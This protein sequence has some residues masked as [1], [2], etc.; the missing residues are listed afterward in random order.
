[1]ASVTFKGAKVQTSG[2]LP[3]VG[4]KAPDFIL[5]DSDLKDRTLN[6]FRGRRKLISIVPSLDTAVCAL[7][8]KKFNDAAKEHPGITILF[9]S[10]DLPFAQKRFCVGD[11][12][13]NIVT[14]SMMR[15]K[16]FAQKYGILITDGPLAGLCSRSILVLDEN[17][18]V[19]YRELV[20]EI[21]QEPNYQKALE[22]LLK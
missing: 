4:V 21:T 7:S 16:D 15:S 18:K 5:T 3:Q 22:A 2:D 8:A 20:P 14:L 12:L 9:V 6:D 17:D 10:A 11:G 1:M 13:Q 19:I